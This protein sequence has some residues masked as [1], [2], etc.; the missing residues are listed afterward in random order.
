[1]LGDVGDPQLVG[2]GA[3]EGLLDQVSGDVVG[4][5]ALPAPSAG[6]ARDPGSAHEHL[7]CVVADVHA[8]AEDELDVRA[9]RAVGPA[10]AAVG[11]TDQVGEPLMPPLVPTACGRATPSCRDLT[12]CCQ[13][14]SRLM[15]GRP[16]RAEWPRRVL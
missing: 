15:G 8:A 9:A 7:D 5:D 12:R 11:L 6:Q 10:G 3:A 14:A 1:M 16:P 13:A 2:A 4:L